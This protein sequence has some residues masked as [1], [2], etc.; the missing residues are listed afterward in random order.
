MKKF[1]NFLRLLVLLSL[2]NSATLLHAQPA[3]NDCEGAIGMTMNSNGSCAA[4]SAVVTTGAT[5]SAP[6][7]ISGTFCTNVSV[8]DDVW[9]T[10]TTNSNQTG[11]IITVSNIIA[12]SGTASS[13]GGAVYSGTCGGL[14]Q[15]ICLAS[16]ISNT[17]GF[18]GLTGNTTYFLRTWAGGSSNSATYTLC[19]QEGPVPPNCA[20]GQSP[21]SGSVATLFCSPPLSFPSSV[22]FNWTPPASGP[23]PTS[24]RFYIGTN[25]P[26]FVTSVGGTGGSISG[27][28]PNTT[29]NWYVVPGNGSDAVGC[30]VPITFTTGPE[31][32]CVDNNSCATATIVGTAGNGG[33]VTST[34]TEASISQPGETCATRTGNA[35]DD[36]WFRFTTDA[37]GGDV[38]VALTGAAA[39]LNA[40]IQV[41]S[42]SCGALT[43]IG[44]A[45]ASATGGSNETV[46]LTALAAST[47]YS[48]RVYG[49]GAFN[50]ATPTSGAFTLSTSGSGVAGALPISLSSFTAQ[51]DGAHNVVRWTTAQ[52]HNSA[53]MLIE[54]GSDQGRFTAI[55]TSIT[56][57]GDKSTST[58]YAW[59]DMRP[60]AGN[61][62]YRLR[63]VD[64][65]GQET[66]SEVV[67]VQRKSEQF[68]IT[69]VYPS[70][71]T[72]NVTVQFN[73]TKEEKVTIRLMDM[74]G[75]LVMQQV[76]EA[77]KD[78]N[79]LPFTLNGL[80]AGVYSVTVSNSAGVSTP[81]R[82][83]KQ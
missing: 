48:V 18:S 35:D 68:G 55:S 53:Y 20:T 22:I 26:L 73:S 62:Y 44:C 70:P 49:F 11:V 38:T 63:S 59:T 12:T 8:N 29:Y 64:R 65:D 82:F 69:S 36:V 15:L 75:R 14:T 16:G 51:A 47:T 10:F 28:L 61:N 7:V 46:I 78:I 81:V 77:V 58:H 30:N 43:N 17:W 56:A 6:T 19:V 25:T 40:V 76:N 71:T 37:T 34:T 80:Q 24:Y 21:A 4:T 72:D 2:G 66:I 13:I 33:S 32:N 57:Q 3:N 41:Y 1:T 79:E 50:S 23:M 39:A 54:R 60:L 27:L 5:T 83:V 9:Y 67:L 52:E 31:P 45:D 42:G 74:T